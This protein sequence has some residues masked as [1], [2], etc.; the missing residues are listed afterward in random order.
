MFSVSKAEHASSTKLHVME[1]EEGTIA[2]FY[3]RNVCLLF[4]RVAGLAS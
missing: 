3:P 1:E 4:N 2:L